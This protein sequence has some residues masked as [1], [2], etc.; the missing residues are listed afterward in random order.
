MAEGKASQTENPSECHPQDDLVKMHYVD[1]MLKYDA[2]FSNARA[3]PTDTIAW[4]KLERLRAE[5]IRRL[6]LLEAL[7]TETTP[8][9]DKARLRCPRAAG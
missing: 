8:R 4:A 9:T 3:R 1:L 2:A 6:E 7:V 5:V